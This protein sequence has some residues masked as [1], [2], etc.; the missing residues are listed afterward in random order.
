MRI[1]ID[2]FGSSNASMEYIKHFKF[3]MV[4]FDRDYVTNLEDKTTYAMLDSL[5]KM[6]KDLE[7]S[8]VAKWVDN[9]PQKKKLRQLGIDYIQGFGVSNPINETELI[10][11]YN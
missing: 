9:D 10:N 2:N 4:Q 8:T 5:I 1:C 7:V 6:S 11:R 3:D